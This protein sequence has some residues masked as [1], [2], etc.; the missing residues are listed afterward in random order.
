MS[1]ALIHFDSR[2]RDKSLYPTSSTFFV[3]FPDKVQSSVPGYLPADVT[4]VGCEMANVANSVMKD[5]CTVSWQHT[6]KNH[7]VYTVQ[8]DTGT[9]TFNSLCTQLLTVLNSVKRQPN[10]P[11]F[12]NDPVN[13]ELNR[14][15]H[16]AL[17]YASSPDNGLTLASLYL[18]QS[19]LDPDVALEV[20]V[21]S[22]SMICTMQDHNLNVNDNISIQGV[23]SQVGGLPPSAYINTTFQVAS[24]I[25]SSHFTVQLS[26]GAYEGYSVGL[27]NEPKMSIGRPV[28]FKFLPASTLLPSMGFPKQSGIIVGHLDDLA[29]AITTWYAGNRLVSMLTLP[30]MPAPLCIVDNHFTFDEAEA[31][32]LTSE[33]I[34]R[35]LD[36]TQ[37]NFYISTRDLEAAATKINASTSISIP[38]EQSARLIGISNAAYNRAQTN[39]L[40]NGS[41][42]SSVNLSGATHCFVTSPQCKT[43]LNPFGTIAKIQMVSASGYLNFNNI[44]GQNTPL[45]RN[46]GSRRTGLL[47]QF[48][49]ESK[50]KNTYNYG[51]EVSGTLKLSPGW[52]RKSL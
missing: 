5:N 2:D 20:S 30:W 33:V 8:L 48:L 44:I 36:D 37:K 13:A 52:G 51:L 39:I 49:D 26:Q 3:P 42:Y 31:I 23:V 34:F 22:T 9:Y 18:T 29:E 4:L 46:R 24:V 14:Q 28:E 15:H 16:W 50:R 45:L 35:C 47:L 38:A 21:G 7:P 6:D 1:D 32:G 40:S 12:L 10:D 11:I 27:A 19:G 43:P 41:L 25:D 17:D